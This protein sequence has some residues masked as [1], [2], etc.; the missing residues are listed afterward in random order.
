MTTPRSPEGEMVDIMDLDR[1]IEGLRLGTRVCADRG[2]SLLAQLRDDIDQRAATLLGEDRYGQVESTRLVEAV[3]PRRRR[4]HRLAVVPIAGALVLASTGAAAALSGSPHAPL[5]PLHRLIFGTTASSAGQISRDLAT[6]QLLLNHAAAQPY[7]SRTGDLA[8]ART[9]LA[10]AQRLL[11]EAGS[12][13]GQLSIKVSAALARLAQL[14]NPPPAAVTPS[15]APRPTPA[16]AQ[17]PAAPEASS[18][19]SDSSGVTP[20]GGESETPEGVAAG[21]P[22]PA[23]E[24]P[25]AAPS[26]APTHVSGWKNDRP[27]GGESEAPETAE[28]SGTD[29]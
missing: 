7:A 9:L 14:E 4:R 27:A 15:P 20:A 6:A 1:E 29:R 19:E 22:A 11:P 24:A 5:Y 10:D 25:D 13:R 16:G 2:L 8:R 17:P 26:T 3:V 23:T 28:P 12:D 18:G 21:V